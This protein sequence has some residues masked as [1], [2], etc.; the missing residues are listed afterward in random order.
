LPHVVQSESMVWSQGS[1][2]V[3]NYN[4]SLGAASSPTN[5]SGVSVSHDGGTTFTRLGPPGPFTGHVSDFGDPIVVY[6]QKLAEWFAGDLVGGAGTGTC[7]AQGI[8]LW[9]STD[10]DTWTTGA[11]A[12]T[13]TSD[14]RE[15]MWVDNNPSSPFY[16]RMYISFNNFAVSGGALQVTH[17]D[18]GTTWTTPVTLQ[19]SFIRQA[20]ITV[21]SD[22]TV[23]EPAQN[24]NGGHL[25][26]L[27]QQNVMFRSTD[28]GVTWSS[29]NMGGTFSMPGDSA[30]T[31]NT[32]FPKISPIWRET[33]YGIPAVGPNGVVMYVYAAHGAGS[34]PSD[35]YFIRSTDN[36]V[37]WGT[38][39]KLNTD[40]TTEPQWMPSLRVTPSGVVEAT[41][42]DRRN[43]SD[44]TNY[45]RFARI[46]SDNGATWGPDQAL[47]TVLIPQP[48]QADSSVQACYAGDYNYTTAS[49]NTGFDTWTDGRVSI[50]PNGPQQDVF[51]HQ[52]PL[53]LPTATAGAPGT[54]TSSS[55]VLNGTINPGGQNTT[56]LLQY[57]ATP[58]LG[59]QTSAQNVGSGAA[60]VPVQTTLT[61]LPAA[62]TLYYRF[63]A[64]N[65]SG[66]SGQ[67]AT[68]TAS[69]KPNPT[70]TLRAPGKITIHTAVVNGTVNPG[71]EATT[72]LVQYGTTP[73]LGKTTAAQSAGNGTANV[74]VQTTLSGLPGG[75]TIY[76][77]FVA[78]NDSGG[79]GQS[80]VAQL[81]TPW[82][83]LG[84]AKVKKNDII[85]LPATVAGAGRLKCKATFKQHGKKVTYGSATVKARG[86]GKVTCKIKPSSAA[87]SAL[88]GGHK[89]KVSITAT[90]NST[91]LKTI[92]NVNG[93]GIFHW[94]DV[95]LVLF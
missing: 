53:Q 41:W 65:D 93:N 63:V 92:L 24:E 8:G 83:T 21:G 7:G 32:Y 62:S 16:G 47:S 90:F 82:F 9:T 66:G 42:Y 84:K 13:G 11:C 29:S 35:V 64:N 54:I 69:I 81:K 30:C 60:G 4:D 61:G 52:I 94:L 26:N 55:A 43:T 2:I 85:T 25:P 22:G 51:F 15:S 37:T 1:T 70:A 95:S 6:N 38:P 58:A 59:Q 48:N 79:S 20:E 12:H 75:S 68:Q 71:G 10:A 23:F 14:D 5:F 87:G 40:S 3:V 50:S 72:W 88:T 78:N 77:K 57:G 44:G 49:A 18:D 27:G 19:N 67:S 76:Y 33:G 45:E 80:G 73:A 56:W 31:S 34:D 74:P 28:G 46:S 86:A 91:T 36:G 89:L 39:V 17:S